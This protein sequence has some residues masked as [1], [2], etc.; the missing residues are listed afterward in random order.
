MIVQG[1]E[2]GRI[3]VITD[4]QGPHEVAEQAALSGQNYDMF[5][6]AMAR[7]GNDLSQFCLYALY[8]LMPFGNK[9]TNLERGELPKRISDLKSFLRSHDFNM[10]VTLGTLPFRLLTG[11]RNLHNYQLSVLKAKTE[12]GGIKTLPLFHPREVMRSYGDSVFYSFAG[13]KIAQEQYTRLLTAPNRKFILG[14]SLEDALALLKEAE[15]CREVA[16]DVETGR[17]QINTF[18]FSLSPTRA[19]AINVLPENYG[20]NNYYRLW[21]GIRRLCE[22]TVPK[23]AQNALY[24]LS[25]LSYYGIRLNNVLHDTM[26]CM[27]FLHP[28]L[29]ANLGNVG[30]IYT[31]FPYWKDENETWNDIRD[32]RQHYEYNCKDTTGTHWAYL[33]QRK[34][35]RAAGQE[36]FYYRFIQQLFYPVA[37]MCSRGLRVDEIKKNQLSEVTQR[38]IDN[39]VK[40]INGEL[41]E[42]VG[43]EINVRSGPQLKKALK[44]LDMTLPMVPD[45]KT[46]G[47]RPSTDKKALAKLKKK[48][49][50]EP[51]LTHLMKYSKENKLMTSYLNFQYHNDGRV[52]Y[53]INFVATETG[54]FNSTKDFLGRGFNAQTIPKFVRAM[55]P[56]NP[57][58]YLMQIDLKQAESRYVAWDAPEPTL[59]QLINDGRDIHKFVAGR[60]FSVKETEVTTAQRNLGKKSGHAANYGVGPRTF[61]DSCLLDGIDITEAEAKR[62][63]E[64]YHSVFP[65]IRKRQERIKATLR[66][67]KKLKTPI[68]RSRMFHGRLND[69]TFREAFAYCPQSV[70]PDIT[71]HLMLEFWKDPKVNLL[72]QV[73]DSLL[74]EV[75]EEHIQRVIDTA[76]DLERWHPKITLLGGDLW[77]PTDVEVGKSWGEMNTV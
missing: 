4:C 27:K 14:P 40:K 46:G 10:V 36:G 42:R 50:K 47:Q 44:D 52:R 17:G 60:I 12:Y 2:H 45:P 68:G 23:I 73:H 54:R 26:A 72:L 5:M 37:E 24:E 75:S 67:Y 56:A 38:K 53:A 19:V 8:P 13:H 63:I 51:I 16:I 70:I 64:G 41:L 76:E 77:I 32:W 57:G 7:A 65:G 43:Y 74:L 58:K 20:P 55:F 62:I 18:G 15:S 1:N 49:P 34:D 35:L 66:S 39:Y 48:H 29:R 3:L 61:A 31:P 6:G 71:N 11:E 59:Q 21:D 25:W 22:G 28:E 69:A 9:T 33:E 30:R